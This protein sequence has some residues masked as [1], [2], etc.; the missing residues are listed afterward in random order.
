MKARSVISAYCLIR[1]SSPTRAGKGRLVVDSRF[2]HARVERSCF[3]ALTGLALLLGAATTMP[4]VAHGAAGAVSW[5]LPSAHAA[6]NEIARVESLPEAER[7]RFRAL[8]R[9]IRCLVCQ[10]QSIADSHAEL[11]QDLRREVLEKVEAGQ[12]DEEILEFLVTRYGDFVL[13]RPPV[14]QNTVLLWAGP[15]L[16]VLVGGVVFFRVIRARAAMPVAPP[17]ALA[18]DNPTDEEQGV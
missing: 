18:G 3:K 13:Y 12:S 9:E 5:L 1:G 2:G 7:E 8:I 17:D 15:G 11:A 6:D 4:G 10:N 16:L 14:K